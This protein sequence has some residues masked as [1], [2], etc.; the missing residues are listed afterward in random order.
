MQ[1]T[2]GNK[3]ITYSVTPKGHFMRT[4]EVKT[5]GF[6]I[7]HTTSDVNK[8]VGLMLCDEVEKE[9]EKLLRELGLLKM[10]SFWEMPTKDSNP[11]HFNIELYKRVLAAKGV[12]HD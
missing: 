7:I 4:I 3:T 1:I 12:S 5:G 11:G 9:R 10:I 6:T 2:T 8:F